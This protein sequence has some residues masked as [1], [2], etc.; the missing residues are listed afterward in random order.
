MDQPHEFGEFEFIDVLSIDRLRI[1]RDSRRNADKKI[2]MEPGVR[3][4]EVWAC[5]YW[6]DLGDFFFPFDAWDCGRA[7]LRLEAE[8][9]ADYRVSARFS[10]KN[11]NARLWIVDVASQEIVA[12]SQ[13]TVALQY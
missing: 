1:D 5:R 3:K 9:G 12:G 7:V 13:A 10:K 11:K 2:A 8:P 6:L 4:V